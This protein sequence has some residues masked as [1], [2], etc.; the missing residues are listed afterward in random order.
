M[1]MVGMNISAD[2][3]LKPIQTPQEPQ[4]TRQTTAEP[5]KKPTELE[6]A[7]EREQAGN[8]DREIV[9]VSEDG[10]TVAVARE[11]IETE[12]KEGTVTERDDEDARASASAIEAERERVA[13]EIEAPE[14]EPIELP[15]ATKEANEAAIEEA[16]E[17]TDTET[18]SQ[19]IISF[20]GY[21]DS[22]I[23]QMYLDG[24]ISQADYNQEIE[25]REQRLENIE[26]SNDELSRNMNSI[27]S[28]GRNAEQM[29]NAI[30][31]AYSDK[32]SA[33]LTADQRMEAI[34]N[35]AQRN[36]ETA[37][38]TEDTKNLWDYQL[39]A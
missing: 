37:R 19:Q 11:A 25:S 34:E 30:E 26:V 24:E 39:R 18:A 27:D 21:T 17:A 36:E 3:A 9:S 28:A 5:E 20:A 1:A 13:V 22:Q 12:E 16:K 29:G 32:A 10:D 15:E 2:P 4:Q 8:E 35:L 23:E 14:I 6:V 33:T 7:A 31:T 38:R